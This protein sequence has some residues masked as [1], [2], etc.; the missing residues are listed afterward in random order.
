MERETI[1]E[2]QERI[3]V[4]WVDKLKLEDEQMKLESDLKLSLVEIGELKGQIET[5][6]AKSENEEHLTTAVEKQILLQDPSDIPK[7]VQ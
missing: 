3:T 7:L 6:K 4:L 5:L 2:L 1:A